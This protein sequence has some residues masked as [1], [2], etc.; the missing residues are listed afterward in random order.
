M[1]SRQNDILCVTATCFVVNHTL[2]LKVF[3]LLY[4]KNKN[5]SIFVVAKL[6]KL[7]FYKS[8]NVLLS[9]FPH[10]PYFCESTVC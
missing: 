7:I 9:A 4:T 10:N 8:A 6:H 3:L 2:H 1:K 5:G